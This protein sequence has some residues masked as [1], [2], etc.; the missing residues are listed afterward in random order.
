MSQQEPLVHLLVIDDDERL[1]NLLRKYLS[2]HGFLVTLA[3]DA[4][5]GRRLLESLQFDL[6]ILDVMMP[7][8]DGIG[9]LQSIRSETGIKTPVIFLTANSMVED[10]ITGLEAGADDYIVKPFEPKELLLRIN[11]ILRRMPIEEETQ[12]LPTRFCFG[13][14]RYEILEGTLWNGDALIKLTPTEIEIMRILAAQPR[15]TL[16]RG[17][18]AKQLRRNGNQMQDRAIDVQITRLRRK[19]EPN[20]KEPRY[21]QTVR[22]SGY[23]LIPDPTSFASG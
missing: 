4:L 13:Q 3:R 9:F 17:M 2:L 12:K 8:E 7:G 21:L 10:R 23:T 15:E 11:S 1:R 5:H 20:P 16:H 18:L 19:I 6:I 22:G 14:L